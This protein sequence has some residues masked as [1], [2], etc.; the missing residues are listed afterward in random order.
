MKDETEVPFRFASFKRIQALAA[1]AGLIAISMLPLFTVAGSIGTN[2]LKW[3]LMIAYTVKQIGGEDISTWLALVHSLSLAAVAPF[4]GSL[5]DVTGR[6]YLAIAGAVIVTVGM[7]VVGTAHKMPI[8]ILGMGI[9]GAG[10]GI[11][12]VT[13]FAGI[14]E[15]V[16]VHS[17]G[18]YM[19][20][21]FMVFSPLAASTP[22]G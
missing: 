11:T 6:R 20:T 18:R 5:S 17:R 4:A 21:I 8:A 19:G 1:L 12:G 2:F 22:Y 7:V 15:L 10:S 13:G 3:E 9:A 14:V 16:P